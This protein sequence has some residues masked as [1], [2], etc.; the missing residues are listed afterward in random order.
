MKEYKLLDDLQKLDI[1]ID[2]L[3]GKLANLPE[4]A[5][6]KDLKEQLKEQ[7]EALKEKQAKLALKESAQKKVEGELELLDLKIKDEDDK[8]YSGTIANPKELKSIQQEVVLL[9]AKKDEIET[10][11]L[12]LLDEADSLKEET[13]RAQ[14]NSKELAKRVEEAEKKYKKVSDEIAKKL[15]DLKGKSE[16]TAKN[17]SDPLISV[18]RGIREKKKIAAVAIADGICQG[19]FVELPA[20]EVDK[21]LQTD[22]L[23]RCPQCRRII[24]R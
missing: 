9:R 16:A 8:L 1:E 23:W 6:L 11:L 19:C 2:E 5:D 7:E 18:Y 3:T 22:E 24:I 17:I 10:G 12:E 13:N 20:E 14:S 15:K 21:M 4:E